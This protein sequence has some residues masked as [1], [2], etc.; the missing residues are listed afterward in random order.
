MPTPSKNLGKLPPYL[1]AEIDRKIDEAKKQGVDIISLG[2]GDPDLPTPKPI[3]D[4]LL[5]AAADPSTH[6]YP[7]Y[8]GT[9]EFR[10]TACKWMKDRFGVEVDAN[11]EALSLIGSKEGLAHT[12]V[13]YIEPGDVVLCPSPGYPVY[14]NYTLLMGGEVYTFPLLADND[15]LPDLTTIPDDIA[16]RAKLLFLNY[17]NNPTGAIAPESFI[18]EAVAF[19]KKHDILLCHDNA[20]SEM[21]FDGYRAPSFLSVPGAKEVC[22]EYF[23]LS[24]MYNMTGWRV[25]FAVGNATGIKTL[26]TVKNNTDSGVFKAIQRASVSGLL[27]SDELTKDLNKI[28]GA[29]RDLFV[30]GLKKLGWNFSPSAATFYLWIPVPT[31][32][33]SVDFV[34]L[35]LEKCGVVVPPGT[36]YGP[37]GEGFFRVALTVS[38][39]RLQEVLDRMEKNG[40]TFS[41]LA[42]Q[43]ANAG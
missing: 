39:K 43:P 29:R 19:C 26:G 33:T 34:N 17:P 2:V 36:G 20:Y 25:G 35:M 4:E 38:E 11:T 15:F 24:K 32:M 27:R 16:K 40:V 28:Y 10:E 21:T 42:K 12:I 30:A 3:V 8:H 5:T 18:Q 1:F 41:A 22:V 23:S 31:G 6:N 14:N 37:E 13:A 7:P 9:Q